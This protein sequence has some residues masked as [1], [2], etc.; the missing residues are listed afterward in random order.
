MNIKI[1]IIVVV[2][3]IAISIISYK[4]RINMYN[5]PLL[6]PNTVVGTKK[7]SFDK[8]RVNLAPINGGLEYT[9]SFWLYI[10]NWSYKYGLEKL[11]THWKGGPPVSVDDLKKK[12]RELEEDTAE[13]YQKDKDK[14]GPLNIKEKCKHCDGTNLLEGFTNL[15]EKDALSGLLISL[16]E[17]EN[18]LIIRNTLI[19]GRT[20]TL[21]LNK[22][23]IQKW[24]Y[25]NIILRLRNLDVFING[26]L[27]ASKFFP[28]LPT[29]QNGTLNINPNGGFD[30][31]LSKYKYINRA[32]KISEIRKE[33]KK[34]PKNINPFS[35]NQVGQK[36]EEHV[37]KLSEEDT[38]IDA[39]SLVRGVKTAA[40][41]IGK[42]IVGEKFLAGQLC[43]NDNDCLSDLKC[44]QGK[45]TFQAQSRQLGQTCW[46]TSSCK[47]GLNCND[48]GQDK[49]TK[50]QIEDL[51]KLGIP[52]KSE[53][54]Y[55]I[56]LGD[57][58][59]TC[60]YPQ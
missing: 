23:P 42:K 12:C 58:P 45:C 48:H 21:R 6:I 60:I 14:D 19:D 10:S 17:K 34:G 41:E 3:I 27:V 28:T 55:N 7:I 56:S 30:G 5:S 4:L 46:G 53:N 39:D 1:I 44:L 51:K 32:I 47:S 31:Y 43:H 20:N 13:V 24:L 33:F 16:G 2:I 36:L 38:R 26:E 18:Q 57:K 40:K 22:I 11:I 49:L 9:I 25:V 59:F 52:V 8:E 29:Y 37:S 50:K 54:S 35:N 15:P